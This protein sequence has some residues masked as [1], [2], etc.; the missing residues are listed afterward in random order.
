[1]KIQ[2]GGRTGE[3]AR[4]RNQ[5]L[6]KGD[7]DPIWSDGGDMRW[8]QQRWLHLH[9]TSSGVNGEGAREQGW[10]GRWWWWGATCVLK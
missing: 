6:D 10:G 3:N 1:M 7:S 5:G 8:L 4:W 2:C 9:H